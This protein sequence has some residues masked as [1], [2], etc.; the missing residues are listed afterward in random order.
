MSRKTESLKTYV[1]MKRTINEIEAETRKF[2]AKYKL[3]LNEFAVLE[4]L[5][6]K[7]EM[8][9]QE[10][11]EGILIANSSTTYIVDKLCQKGYVSREFS[12]QDRRVIH[13]K[14]TEQGEA[15]MKT[16]FPLHAEQLNTRFDRLSEQEITTIRQILKKM[17]G[18]VN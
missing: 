4:I 14:L 17:N 12:E 11:K 7:G 5:F 8:A 1:A 18:L 13:V 3:N 2:I 10:L 6:H 16:I 15:L 9:T